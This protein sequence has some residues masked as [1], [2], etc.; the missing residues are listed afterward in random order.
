MRCKIGLSNERNCVS[1]SILTISA[2][3]CIRKENGRRIN[4][5]HNDLEVLICSIDGIDGEMCNFK[6]T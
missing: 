6:L 2:E 1:I 4:G 5:Y 3:S